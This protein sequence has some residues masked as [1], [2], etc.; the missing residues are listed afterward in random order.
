MENTKLP[1]VA[2]FLKQYVLSFLCALYLIQH[3]LQY[4]DQQGSSGYS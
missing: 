1:L 2:K 4:P 3:S